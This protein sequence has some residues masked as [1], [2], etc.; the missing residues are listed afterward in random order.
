MLNEAS[1][2]IGELMACMR[3]G[4]WTVN[5][6]ALHQHDKEECVIAEKAQKHSHRSL[7]STGES[8]K[9]EH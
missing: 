4:A 3:Q 9:F 6:Q 2:F 7:N 1:A 8:E 5:P